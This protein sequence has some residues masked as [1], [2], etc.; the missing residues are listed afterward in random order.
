[1]ALVAL[2]WYTLLFGLVLL[3]CDMAVPV[4][5][6]EIITILVTTIVAQ[7]FINLLGYMRVCR[8]MATAFAP[9]GLILECDF[10]HFAHPCRCN[11]IQS[12]KSEM[13]YRTSRPQRICGSPGSSSKVMPQSF[14]WLTDR[15]SAAC[16]GVNRSRPDLVPMAIMFYSGVREWRRQHASR[17]PFGSAFSNEILNSARVARKCLKKQGLAGERI[18]SSVQRMILNT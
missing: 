3:F 6:I 9:C 8:H 7:L 14:L 15:T 4:I 11:L 18:I 12:S 1:M 10:S 17:L 5:A 13:G 16:L 2:S